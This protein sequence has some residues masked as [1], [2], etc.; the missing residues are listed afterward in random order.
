[1]GFFDSVV[2]NITLS[3]TDLLVVTG[4]V[5]SCATSNSL[6]LDR[7]GTTEL[8]TCLSKVRGLLSMSLPRIDASL[9]KPSI[10]GGGPS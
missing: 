2:V 9:P 4:I 3:Y 10:P 5:S 1:M 8:E 7:I 6:P